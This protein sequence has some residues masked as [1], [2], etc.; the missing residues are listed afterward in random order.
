MPQL[1]PSSGLLIMLTI[2]MTIFVF[3]MSFSMM[4]NLKLKI[5]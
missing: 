5:F 3:S 1:S 2:I 4:N